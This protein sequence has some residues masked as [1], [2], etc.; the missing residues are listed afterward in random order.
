[1]AEMTAAAG[2]EQFGAGHQ[3]ARSVCGGNVLCSNR[4]REAWPAS[5]RIEFVLGSIE[6]ETAAGTAIAAMLVMLVIL[7][8]EG[9]FSA[10]LAQDVIFHQGQFL[11]PFPGA[12]FDFVRHN[13]SPFRYRKKLDLIGGQGR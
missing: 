8:G 6:V 11:A 3:E 1:M 2:T 12:M 13:K 10:F 9:A 5:S 7:T 4:C